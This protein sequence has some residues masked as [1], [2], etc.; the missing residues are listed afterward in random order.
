MDVYSVMNSIASGFPSFYKS[1]KIAFQ[2][3]GCN[4]QYTN[5]RN[6]YGK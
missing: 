5:E 2:P 3:Y 1:T 6:V 4:I